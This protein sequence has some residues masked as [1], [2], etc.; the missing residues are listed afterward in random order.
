[1]SYDIFTEIVRCSFLGGHQIVNGTEHTLEPTILR[2][3]DLLRKS[4][5]FGQ[6]TGM[7]NLFSNLP[8]DFTN[9]AKSEL[10]R[11]KGWIKKS[12]DDKKVKQFQIDSDIF[13]VPI[14]S[15]SAVGIDTSSNTEDTFVCIAFFDNYKAAYHYLENHLHIPKHE[16][17]KAPEFKW[18]KLNS[19]YRQLLD[20]QLDYL[21]GMSCNC[22]LILKTNALKNPD[23]KIIDVFIKLIQGCFSN[24]DHISDSRLRLRSNLFKLSN[25]VQIHCDADFVP[26]TPDK[27]V[28]QFVKILSDGN[29]HTPLHAEKDS[30]ESE[31]IQ[32]T[33]IICGILKERILNKNYDPVNPW[34]FHNKL[35]T[36]TK[37]RDA[38]CYYWERKEPGTDVSV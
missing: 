8:P 1:M 18:N 27:I 37:H 13:L 21:L 33:D 6:K 36:K 34:E 15:K 16:N 12:Y 19:E 29:D 35:K 24:Y 26:L 5:E 14:L 20:Q 2:K 11:K 38:K 7:N 4:P 3:Y 23:E 30:H 25:E 32:V 10:Y 22:V 17:G 31:P 9:T 28:K